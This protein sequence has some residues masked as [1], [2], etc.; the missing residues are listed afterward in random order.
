SDLWGGW[1]MSTAS[2]PKAPSARTAPRL[3]LPPPLPCPVPHGRLQPWFRL[4]WLLGVVLLTVS[5]VGA[6]H[7]LQ[8]RPTE[9]SGQDTKAPA[10]R[11]FSDSPGVVC[12]GMVAVEGMPP[13]GVPLLPVH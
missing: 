2:E 12:E 10:E 1:A 6:T 4:S 3:V 11:G 13:E 5:L 7:V 8:S 9:P